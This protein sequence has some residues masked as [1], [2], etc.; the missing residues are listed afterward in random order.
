[1]SV[2]ER[3][4]EIMNKLCLRRYDTISNLA[5]EFGVS[6]RTIRRDIDILSISEPIYT[7]PGRYS[8]GVYVVDGYY[9]N[10]KYMTDIEISLLNKILNIIETQCLVSQED[11]IVFKRIILNYTKPKVLIKGDIK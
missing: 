10:N 9:I 11:T 8:G 3:R 2:A 5:V 4:R 1:M 6:E 7:Q